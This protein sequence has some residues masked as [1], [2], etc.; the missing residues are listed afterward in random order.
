MKNRE[1]T[2]DYARFIAITLVVIGHLIQYNIDDFDN[3]YIYKIIYSFHMPLFMF[4]S[5]YV[6]YHSIIN[7]EFI[8]DIKQKILYLIY[9]F[10][11]WGIIYQYFHL[12]A[13]DL[14]NIFLYP[15]FGFWFLWVLFWIYFFVKILLY[16]YNRN[17]YLFIFF[18]LLLSYILFF[19]MIKEFDIGL[20][21]YLSIYFIMGV[22]ISKYKI[23]YLNKI[24]YYDQKYVYLIGVFLFLFLANYYDRGSLYY[25]QLMQNNSFYIK[26]FIYLYKVLLAVLGII[27][28]MKI[29][30][31]ISKQ[32]NNNLSYYILL[33]A[34]KYTL[35]IYVTHT[36]FL[37]LFNNFILN[38]LTVCF[39]IISLI[40]LLENNLKTTKKF[41]F[42]KS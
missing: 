41:I 36:F 25:Y 38:V 23:K 18:S 22:F 21:R 19:G 12:G 7:K 31:V 33:I 14:V 6:S 3:N 5:G 16:T 34:Q 15:S 20:I 35:E 28:T 30:N 27:L 26:I 8:L 37:F 39:F 24:K 4:I 29:A 42:G 11:L 13:V 2:I 40:Y 32:V 17:I 9:P 10:I 1:L